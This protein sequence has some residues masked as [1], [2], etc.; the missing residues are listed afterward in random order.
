MAH[1]GTP[2]HREESVR[3]RLGLTFAAALVF[4]ALH[5]PVACAADLP[6]E[7]PPAPN[8]E[9]VSRDVATGVYAARTVLSAVQSV[10]LG[11]TAT[12]ITVASDSG[13]HSITVD[14]S[15]MARDRKA[16][17]AGYLAGAYVGLGAL[18]RLARVLRK[19]F[20][21]LG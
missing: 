2:A 16:A 13:P 9:L 1:V 20:G 17:G 21:P 6:L 7:Q 18:A 8:A 11:K 3:K 19:A 5:V 10:H 14:Y 15:E 4:A 12:V